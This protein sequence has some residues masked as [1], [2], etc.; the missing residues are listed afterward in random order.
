MLYS[1]C[2]PEMRAF[3]NSSIA[4]IPE[5]NN[6]R[7]F[8][9]VLWPHSHP[10][11]LGITNLWRRILP[12]HFTA[13]LSSIKAWVLG[14]VYKRTM[15]L[16]ETGIHKAQFVWQK[17]LWHSQPHILSL[18]AYTFREYRD[19]VLI[20]IVQFM[21]SAKSRIRFGL[22]IVF[23]CLYITPS[24]YHHCAKLIWRH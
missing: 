6:T 21:M 5:P 24:H 13:E 17:D 4:Q 7:L 2:E 9:L 20:I 8:L 12:A 10:G 19:F 16:K 14:W 3:S 23:V 11:K 22:Q 1:L 18:I 15:P